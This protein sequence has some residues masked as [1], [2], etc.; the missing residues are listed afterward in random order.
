MNVKIEGDV[1]F[2]AELQS[3]LGVPKDNNIVD[4]DTSNC[5]ITYAELDENHITLTCGH[6]FNYL[7]LYHEVVKQKS[8]SQLEI[9]YLSVN[10]IK[11]PYCRTKTNKLLPYI[12]HPEVVSKRG[13]NYPTKYCMTLHTCTWVF[14]SGK[15]KGCVCGRDAISGEAGIYCAMHHRLQSIKTKNEQNITNM[16]NN[17]TNV[18]EELYKKH[19]V[20]DLKKLLRSMKLNVTGNKKMLVNRLLSVPVGLLTDSGVVV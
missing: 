10:Q 18:H 12:F 14:K 5:L 20:Q 2:F 13:V 16:I 15:N 17:W 19:N 9:S 8:G 11:C 6:K 4:Q 1:D 3:A 7:P